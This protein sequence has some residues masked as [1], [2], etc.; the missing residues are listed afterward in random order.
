MPKRGGGGGDDDGDSTP[1][2]DSD[3]AA[4][5]GS[6][7]GGWGSA[8]GSAEY[9]GGGAIIEG[10]L[11]VRMRGTWP[12]AWVGVVVWRD[13]AVGDVV[14]RLDGRDGVGVEGDE[15]GAGAD[16]AGETGGEVEVG[17]G[18]VGLGRGRTGWYMAADMASVD[19]K[20]VVD[21]RAPGV[22]EGGLDCGEPELRR[23]GCGRVCARWFDG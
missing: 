5:S 21:G 8:G 7:C 1:R 2:P 20:P 6:C 18:V 23:Y 19:S 13:S 15:S 9:G 16:A 17:E 3:I 22:G 14:W 10:R 4:L 12:A 11:K